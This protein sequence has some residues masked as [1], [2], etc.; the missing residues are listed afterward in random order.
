MTPVGRTRRKVKAK[1]LKGGKGIERSFFF[2]ADAW[3]SQKRVHL[4]I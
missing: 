1:P 4:G 3:M 2:S